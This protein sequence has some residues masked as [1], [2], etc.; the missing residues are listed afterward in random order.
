[1]QFS[2]SSK[3][4]SV[5]AA[6][7]ESDCKLYSIKEKE[8]RDTGEEKEDN[9]ESLTFT[10][11][12]KESKE[13]GEENEKEKENEED[14]SKEDDD[15]DEDGE[16]DLFE[17][18]ETAAVTSDEHGKDPSQNVVQFSFD[19]SHV[20]TGGDDGCMRIW[21]VRDV[22]FELLICNFFTTASRF[23]GCKFQ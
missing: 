6:S 3:D 20:L 15:I 17:L 10:D 13:S 19:G 8:N 16:L 18:C 2:I 11:K 12:E 1:M 5:L 4:T 23:E 7:V 14:S 22:S 9:V 21:K